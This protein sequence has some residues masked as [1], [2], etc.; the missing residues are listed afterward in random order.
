MFDGGKGVK[1][2]DALNY[3][4]TLKNE[5]NI[6]SSLIYRPQINGD[7]LHD[8]TDWSQYSRPILNFKYQLRPSDPVRL[9]AEEEF[10]KL[11]DIVDYHKET[12]RKA[13]EQRLDQLMKKY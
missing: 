9:I 1:L 5:Y 10:V 6:N 11:Q 12:I 13:L 2:E 7:D 8:C 4:T 3:T